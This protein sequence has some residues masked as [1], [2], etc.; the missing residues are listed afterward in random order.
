[1]A[2][3]RWL[4][5]IILIATILLS[6]WISTQFGQLGNEV[7]GVFIPSHS[8]EANIA[9]DYAS[10]AVLALLIAFAAAMRFAFFDFLGFGK[11]N[12]T[13]FVFL[14]VAGGL[15]GFFITAAGKLAFTKLITG[16]IDPTLGFIFVNIL[17][18][19]VETFLFVGAL[20]PS[21][22]MFIISKGKH[23]LFAVGVAAVVVS[24]MF[25]FWHVVATGGNYAEMTGLFEFCMIMCASAKITKSIAPAL[26]EHF[27][28]NVVN[29]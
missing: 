16:A 11:Q 6:L 2:D 22:E 28:L 24:V 14:L 23:T 19:V 15:I 26:G 27:I 17:A 29:G 18:V 10:F 20:F 3:S 9:K 4:D 5:A 7:N 25:A 13:Q 12:N 21:L 1:M 8:V